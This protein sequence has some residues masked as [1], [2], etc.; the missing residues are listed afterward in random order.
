MSK[1]D[2]EYKTFK[3]NYDRVT[4]YFCERFSHLPDD[5]VMDIFAEMGDR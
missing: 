5:L 3:E 1:G 4:S 2:P